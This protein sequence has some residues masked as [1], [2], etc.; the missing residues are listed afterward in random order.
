[1]SESNLFDLIVSSNPDTLA[2]WWCELNSWKWPPEFPSELEPKEALADQIYGI[3]IR[4]MDAIKN[5]VGEKAILYHWNCVKCKCKTP[6]EFEQW[7]AERTKRK[8]K[9]CDAQQSNRLSD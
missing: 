9:S 1:M 7:Y 3:R 2:E 8:G 5:R 6:E 4:L